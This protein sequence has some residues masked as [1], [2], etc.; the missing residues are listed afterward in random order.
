MSKVPHRI[1]V[2]LRYDDKNLMKS[3]NGYFRQDASNFLE[4]VVSRLGEITSV[5][6]VKEVYYKAYERDRSI[7]EL[8]MTYHLINTLAPDLT[9]AEFTGIETGAEAKHSY[10]T[11]EIEE[12]LKKYV[13]D[14]RPSCGYYGQSFDKLHHSIFSISSLK[15]YHSLKVTDLMGVAW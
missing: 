9:A 12:S 2:L 14:R 3:K 6:Q 11:P 13:I 4:Y 10:L 7:D 15:E 5:E 8:T 1:Y